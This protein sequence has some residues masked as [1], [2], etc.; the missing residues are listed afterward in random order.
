MANPGKLGVDVIINNISENP[1]CIHGPTILFERFHGNGQSRQFY[2]CSACRDRRDCSFFH[3]AD[4]KIANGKKDLWTGLIKESRQGK[5]HEAEYKRLEAIKA[6]PASERSYCTSC[7]VLL[8]GTEKSSHTSCALIF[9]ITNKQLSHPSTFLPPKES[10]K[11]EAQ[12]LFTSNSVDVIIGML[13]NLQ[14]SRVLCIGA[15]RIH[16]AI[17]DTPQ[18]N[19]V[20]LMM[21]IDDRY[22]SF[23]SP[24]S[25]LRY[26]MFNHH[27]FDEEKAKN[28]YKQFITENG[29]LV[30]VADPP[31]GGRMELLANDLNKIQNDWRIARG[32][33]SETEL[34]VLFIFPYFMEPQ[35]IANLPS[36][37][38]LDYQVDYDNH[39]LYSSGPKSMKNGSAVRVFV[40]QPRS[41]FPLPESEGYHF[42]KLC[43]RWVSISNKHCD[44]CNGCMSKDGRM[45]RH[46]D[47]CKK[48]NKPSWIHCSKCFRCQPQDHKCEVQAGQKLICHVCGCSGHKRRDCPK[49]KVS[50]TTF[51][52]E[53]KKKKKKN[54]SS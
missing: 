11:L 4:Q 21:D 41:L 39:P 19:M 35:V 51:S 31:F 52:E 44:K 46:C 18:L 22:C 5:S 29:N 7:S 43:D 49:R 14:A 2:A 24:E 10:S 1:C 26:N 47:L 12:Y 9:P 15:P 6:L 38:M 32:L 37:T 40:N 25:C 17:T 33:E 28:T 30:I 45:Y 53:P 54:K 20:S 8:G 36:Y 50:D 16:E 34:P 42:C 23:F 48:C 27:F 13:Q 3:W